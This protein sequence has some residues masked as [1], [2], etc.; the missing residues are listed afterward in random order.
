MI[1]LD[2]NVASELMKPSAEPAVRN[3]I[4]AHVVTGLCTTSVTVAEN[5]HGIERLPAGRR[6]G[7]LRAAA[8]ALFSAFAGQVLPFDN[9]AA[10]LYPLIV[11]SRDHAGLP[12]GG[13]DAQIASICRSHGAI[14]ATRNV[15]DFHDTGIDVIDPWQS[16]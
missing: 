14:L 5:L 16:T 1:V 3:W 10:E 12:I 2:T 6:K 4:R 13:F 11:A 7:Q 15:K 8:E 9:S